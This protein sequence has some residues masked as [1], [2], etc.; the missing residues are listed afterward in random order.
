METWE[1]FVYIT[2]ALLVV[3][4]CF[5]SPSRSNYQVPGTGG[6][7]GRGQ[8]GKPGAEMKVGPVLRN[9]FGLAKE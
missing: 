6:R 2:A 7:G 5:C 3:Y 4:A 1:G 9:D 8:A